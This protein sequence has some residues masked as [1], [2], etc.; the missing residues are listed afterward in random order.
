MSG[1]ISVI[2]TG[3]V[4][5]V[6]GTTFAAHGNTVYCVDNNLNKLETLK[7]GISPIFEPGLDW[8]L[9]KNYEENRL[10]FTSDLL[11]AVSNTE[12]IFLCLPTPPNEDGSADL[13]HILAVTEDIARLIQDNDLPRNKIIVDKSTVPV[14][15]GEKVKAIFDKVLG[16]NEIEVVSNPE[17]LRE[18]FAIEDAMK[19]ERVVIGTESERVKQEM[20][21]LYE[22]FVRTG[23][24][25][26]FMDVKSAELTKY[27]ANSFLATKISF[28]NDLARYCDEVGADIELVRH[29]IGSD[30][31]IGNR[32]LFPGVGYGGSCFPKDVRALMY[33]KILEATHLVNESQIFYFFSKIK[34]RFEKLNG[35]KF[36]V[37]GL[38]FKPNTDDTRES[39]AFRIIDLLL[40][41][42]AQIAAYDPEA[43]DN[44]KLKYGTAIEFV[45]D[46]YD[47]L[48]GTDAVLLITEWGLF[49]RPDFDRMKE[50][51]KQK[52]IF[53][54]RNQFDLQEIQKTGFEYYSIGRRA[55]K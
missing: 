17:F 22:P 30:S 55:V 45:K 16:Q 41:E 48:K 42:G 43:I 37:W 29:G 18:G 4:G 40:K 6:S 32:F 1:K 7:K 3:Y 26:I 44:S 8:L 21:F 46:P 27:A 34:D 13:Q 9:K 23:N 53:D 52:I 12:M 10:I 51:M 38:S 39:P 24:P 35:L 31:R 20:R 11:E 33:S 47:V 15:T 5:I 25:I 2:G 28:M 19:P 36:A 50:L 49:R 54:G 14:G